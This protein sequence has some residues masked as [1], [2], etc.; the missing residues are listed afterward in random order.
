MINL[1]ILFSFKF[2]IVCNFF[3]FRVEV[4][5]RLMGG[6]LIFYVIIIFSLFDNI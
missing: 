5:L 6:N 2:L 3:Y 4:V 1:V